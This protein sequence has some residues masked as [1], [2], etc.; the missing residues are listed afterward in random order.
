MNRIAASERGCLAAVPDHRV[1]IVTPL[2]Q[3]PRDLVH[4][5][6]APGVAG[7]RLI[8]RDVQNPHSAQG[9]DA[10]GARTPKK[11]PVR[12]WPNRPTSSIRIRVRPRA[13]NRALAEGAGRPTT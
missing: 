4:V 13:T 11:G 2:C 8:R 9:Y 6:T 1:N 3:F 12:T 7:K 5:D 10:M